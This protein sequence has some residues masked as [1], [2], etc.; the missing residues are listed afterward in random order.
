[1]LTSKIELHS[2]TPVWWRR[3]SK[4]KSNE[5]SLSLLFIIKRV[6]DHDGDGLVSLSQLEFIMFKTGGSLPAREELK[7]AVKESISC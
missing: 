7:E 2:L 4:S 6:F 1:M 5:N 3:L